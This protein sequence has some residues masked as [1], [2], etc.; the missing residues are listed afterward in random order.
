MEERRITAVGAEDI[1]PDEPRFVVERCGSAQVRYW[2]DGCKAWH[3]HGWPGQ[4]T[5]THR[6]SHCHNIA[7]PYDNLGVWLLLPEG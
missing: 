6:I 4:E 3:R 7:S 2:C 5:V 1:A